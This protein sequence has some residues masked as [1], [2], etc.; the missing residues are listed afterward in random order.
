[1]RPSLVK[2][3]HVNDRTFMNILVRSDSMGWKLWYFIGRIKFP[4]LLKLHICPLDLLSP[5]CDVNVPLDI[6]AIGFEEIVDLNASNIV[7][8]R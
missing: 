7:S 3:N 2:I 1:M 4:D 5:D 8:A 6:F